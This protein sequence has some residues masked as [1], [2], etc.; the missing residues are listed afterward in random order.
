ME[1]L[2]LSLR[3]MKKEH[4]LLKLQAKIASEV[5]QGVKEQHHKF[6]LREQMKAIKKELGIEKDD[7]EAL[8]EK[9]EQELKGKTVPE[10][11]NKVIEEE[12]EKLGVLEN[13]SS[14]FA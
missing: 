14:E 9:Y 6:M 12:L 4:E 1:Q 2:K 13:H 3:L 5:E 7:K 10:A 11:V 8:R